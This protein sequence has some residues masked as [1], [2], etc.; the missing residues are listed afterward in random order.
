[1][2]DVDTQ[3]LTGQVTDKEQVK[4]NVFMKNVEKFA[5]DVK[6]FDIS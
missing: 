2:I 6:D 3:P 4:K 1:M 5:A